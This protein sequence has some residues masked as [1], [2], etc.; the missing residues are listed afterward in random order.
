MLLWE[1]WWHC[2]PALIVL[3]FMV[4]FTTDLVHYIQSLVKMQLDCGK[5]NDSELKVWA[6][7]VH[8]GNETER[9]LEA[10]GDIDAVEEFNASREAK[11]YQLVMDNVDVVVKA[12]HPTRENYGKD[13][14]MVQ[15]MAV[16]H[17]VSAWHLSN[18]YPIATVDTV[19][20]TDFLPNMKDNN[21]LKRDWT[22][23]SARMILSQNPPCTVPGSETAHPGNGKGRRNQ[24]K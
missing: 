10:A 19:E 11:G 13:Y 12:R 8:R 20:T 18:S 2:L 23:L 14:H 9:T 3:E 1:L 5:I 6:D 4:N 24:E 21:K 7:E 16:Q 15:M 22:I 17:R